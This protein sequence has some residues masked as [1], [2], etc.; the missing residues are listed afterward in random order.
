MHFDP[1]VRESYGML[2]YNPELVREKLRHQWLSERQGTMFAVLPVHTR[3]ERDIFSLLMETSRA[4]SNRGQPDW[5][6]LANEWSSHC[7]GKTIFYKV[8]TNILISWKL[9]L[10]ASSSSSL[11]I[12]DLILKHGTTSATKR[13][14]L[15]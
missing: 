5:F 2:P 4:F 10:N 9:V 14:L 15:H 8:N 12:C 11:N 6:R 7:N 3:E 1:R 13:I